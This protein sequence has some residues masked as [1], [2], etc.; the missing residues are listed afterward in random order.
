MTGAGNHGRI[1]GNIMRFARV[2]RR[3]GLPVGPGRMLEAVAAV[4]TVGLAARDGDEDLYRRFLDE[5][6]RAETPQDERR[7]LFATAGFRDPALVERTLRLA[8]SDAVGTQDVAMV[9]M[10]LIANPAATVATWTF[11]KRHWKRLQKRL[12]PMLVTRPIEALPA[13]GT[14]A[15]RRDVARF[16]REHPVA[17]GQRTVRQAL[18]RF[19]AGLAFDERNAAPLR[20]W[21]G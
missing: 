14:K 2:L 12:P 18:E 7:L 16:F 4:D 10:R 9:L 3:A 15:W 8:M 5:S 21:I 13:L 1:A 6:K 19:D 11:M 17:T 20:R